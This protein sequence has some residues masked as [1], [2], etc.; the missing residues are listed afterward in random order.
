VAEADLLQSCEELAEKINRHAPLVLREW[1]RLIRM[2][3]V[4]SPYEQVVTYAG[5]TD[6]VLA[7]ADADEGRRAFLEKRPPQ[8][9]GR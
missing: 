3:V 4:P 7:S 1:K 6:P 9:M 8:F 5:I 2:N